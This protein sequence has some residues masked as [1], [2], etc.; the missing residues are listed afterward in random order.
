MSACEYIMYLK[1]CCVCV[2][3]WDTWVCGESWLTVKD[4]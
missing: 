2:F 3:E 1:G 4:L